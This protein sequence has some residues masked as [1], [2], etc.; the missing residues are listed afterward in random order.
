M[1][2]RGAFGIERHC[3]EFVTSKPLLSTDLQPVEVFLAL[4]KRVDRE[5]AALAKSVLPDQGA[6]QWANGIP[7]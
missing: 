3:L 6:S 1:D 2:Q 5:E 7:A 4:K